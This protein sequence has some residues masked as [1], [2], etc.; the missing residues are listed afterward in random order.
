M[1]KSPSGYINVPR[2]V[3]YLNLNRE[4]TVFWTLS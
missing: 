1:L 4:V 3:E 2:P